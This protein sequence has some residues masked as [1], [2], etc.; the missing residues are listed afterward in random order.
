MSNM[1]YFSRGGQYF[2]FLRTIDLPLGLTA[3]KAQKLQNGKL[4]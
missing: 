1:S 4:F 2:V 3:L